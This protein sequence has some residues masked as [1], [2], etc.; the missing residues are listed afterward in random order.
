MAAD[1]EKENAKTRRRKWYEN[2][3][4]RKRARVDAGLFFLILLLFFIPLHHQALLLRVLRSKL[5]QVLLKLL[6]R[7][8]VLQMFQML[9]DCNFY[10]I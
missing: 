8:L 5:R 7:V 4:A 10:M 3:L 1:E 6:Y 2:H 9:Q